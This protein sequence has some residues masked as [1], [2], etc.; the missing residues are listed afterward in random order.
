MPFI[1]T[2]DRT[3]LFV[4]DWGSGPP[5][6]FTPCVGAAVGPVGLPD[7]RAQCSR[8]A[9]RALRPARPR[10]VQPGRHRLRPGHLADDLVAVIGHFGLHEA[11]LVA[12]SLGSKEAVRYLTRP[13]RGPHHPA[14]AA[15]E[16]MS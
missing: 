1:E 14:G 9:V 8:A 11:T 15:P 12:H 13:R 3:S 5:V 16:G 4:T 2:A 7:P 6:V 10:P